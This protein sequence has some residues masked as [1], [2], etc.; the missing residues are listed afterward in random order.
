M[1]NVDTLAHDVLMSDS[2]NDN[3]LTRVLLRAS[4]NAL[5]VSLAVQN[6]H[7]SR[8]LK[9]RQHKGDR[10][11]KALEREVADLS[12]RLASGSMRHKQITEAAQPDLQTRLQKLQGQVAGL[13]DEA[14]APAKLYFKR[15][16]KLVM[17]VR[18]ALAQ[19]VVQNGVSFAQAYATVV[20]PFQCIEPGRV[21]K[22]HCRDRPEPRAQ[23]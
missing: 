9:Q 16:G 3:D 18:D 8:R 13:Q 6:A 22:L 14:A 10:S 19:Q 4:Q 5:L 20:S 21:I 11:F 15:G 23:R 17:G 2:P 12:Q 7:L 1:G